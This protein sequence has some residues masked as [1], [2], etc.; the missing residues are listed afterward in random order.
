MSWAVR[1]VAMVMLA[2]VRVPAAAQ[3]QAPRKR[4]QIPRVESAPTIEDVEAGKATGVAVSDFLQREPGDLVPASDPTTAYLSYDQDSLYVA[5]VCKSANP[6]SIRARMSRR[7]SIF[8]DDFVGVHLDPFQE[9]QRAYMF[10]SNPIGVQ[11][12]GVTS[13]GS[14]D[15]FSYDAVWTSTGRR[16]PAGYIV[17]FAI[18]FKSL[19]FPSGAD[20]STWGIALQRVMP[21]RSESVF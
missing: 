17:L 2:A 15:D 13:E 12:D 5:F 18:P 20:P 9:R 11:A 8:D 3:D 7:E 19:R 16:T 21:T 6:G 14:G 10:F 4:I 1:C